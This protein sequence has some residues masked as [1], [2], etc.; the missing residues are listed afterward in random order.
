[1]EEVE[2]IVDC[3]A[4][5]TVVG[6]RSAK[7]LAVWK[8]ARKVNVRQG[9]GSHLSGGNFIVNTS[10]KVVNLVLPATAP[11]VLYKILLHAEVLDIGNK[12]CISCLSWLTENS[13][14]VDTQ[15]RC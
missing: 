2:A 1:M 8:R 12:D 7:K 11:T 6:K 9:D 14:L 10:F 3:A 15:H 13:F 5:A 4:S